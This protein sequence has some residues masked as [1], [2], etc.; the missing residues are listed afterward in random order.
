MWLLKSFLSI[1]L[2]GLSM[3]VLA[4]DE[5]VTNQREI[6]SYAMGLQLGAQVARALAHQPAEL[7]PKAIALAIEDIL[8]GKPARFTDDEMTEAMQVWQEMATL[9]MRRQATDNMRES[10]EFLEQNKVRQ[11]IFE[12][13][14]GLQY[15]V[16]SSGVGDFPELSDQVVVHYRGE[17]LDGTEFDSSYSRGEPATF[18]IR[19]VIRGWQEALLLMRPTGRL[20]IFVPPELAYGEKGAGSQIG[21]NQVLIFDIELIE[22]IRAP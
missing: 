10:V 3:M 6:A 16:V 21:P 8:L 7:D 11:G 22:V 9:D 12:T 4:T 1:G 18:G 17:L 5:E 13:D 14:S 20:K 15:K 19:Q 2:V